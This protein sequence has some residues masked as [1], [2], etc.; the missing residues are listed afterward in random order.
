M[1]IYIKPLVQSVFTGKLNW[2]CAPLQ[3]SFSQ[4]L[5]SPPSDRHNGLFRFCWT[6][7]LPRPLI[8]GQPATWSFLYY[9]DP[10]LDLS[11]QS[12]YT[13]AQRAQISAE[14][15]FPLLSVL[16]FVFMIG[17]RLSHWMVTQALNC[18]TLQ[19]HVTVIWPFTASVLVSHRNVNQC[20]PRV[21]LLFC[22]LLCLYLFIYRQI[23]LRLWK[24][25]S[26]FKTGAFIWIFTAT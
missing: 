22:K 21:L 4:T 1:I 7:E 10:T 3:V 8:G 19:L 16:L 14:V 15:R 25:M 13:A 5:E 9:H 6:G 2:D 12:G 11:R 23:N 20:N 24:C 17:A 18:I 26:A